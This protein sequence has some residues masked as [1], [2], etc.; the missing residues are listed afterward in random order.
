MTRGMYAAAG[1]MLVGLGRQEVLANNLANANTPGFKTD[2]VS[3]G[4]FQQVLLPGVR[5]EG[6][7]D[8]VMMQ[9]ATLTA[10]QVD[11]QQGS[12][13]ET[14]N[15]L[16]L[17]ITG[18]ACFV[19]ATPA[20]ER[21]TRNGHFQRAPDGVLV[22]SQGYPVLGE[23]GPLTLPNA[24]VSVSSRGE[25]TAGGM[26]VGRLRTVRFADPANVTKYGDSL[27]A[28]GS[29]VETPAVGIQQG[30]LENS[31]TDPMRTMVEM[32]ATMRGFEMNQRVIQVQDSTLQTVLDVA[33]R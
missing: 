16:D 15:S 6:G 10:S 3:Y 4:S 30:M 2:R 22:T 12:I 14:G 21:Y 33:R 19:V 18:D 26:Y 23:N 1:G 24:E 28:G 9:S 25:V 11:F 17:A 5:G 7:G 29:P 32:I 8:A 27:Y 20:G 13:I 31:N